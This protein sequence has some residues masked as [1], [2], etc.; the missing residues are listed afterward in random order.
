MDFQTDSWDIVA[1][2]VSL[3]TRECLL[4]LCPV[5]ERYIKHL[6]YKAGFPGSPP[7]LVISAGREFSADSMFGALRIEIEVFERIRRI[8]ELSVAEEKIDKTILRALNQ[9]AQRYLLHWIIGHELVHV[10]RRHTEVAGGVRDS[11]ASP[12]DTGRAFE[13]DADCKAVEWLF[14]TSNQYE[15]KA[16]EPF[17]AKLIIAGALHIGFHDCGLLGMKV[18]ADSE[19]S[20]WA[21][22]L[23]DLS[24]KLALIDVLP[25]YQRA[26]EVVSLSNM[27]ALDFTEQ[28]LGIM[29]FGAIVQKQLMERESRVLGDSEFLAAAAR[30]FGGNSS[31]YRHRA[32][33]VGLETYVRSIQTIHG[34]P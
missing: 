10:G 21:I 8:R 1:S 31:E 14:W 17:I 9:L 22:R 27:A 7:Q 25:A 24:E 16:F 3:D 15:L 23:I 34:K 30:K 5:A 12:R 32:A 13:F 4:R 33:W 28:F 20:S 29:R 18:S 6:H 19:Y 2:R 11:I 26:P